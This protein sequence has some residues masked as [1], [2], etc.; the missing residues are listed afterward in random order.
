MSITLLSPS[1][2]IF[3]NTG[4]VNWDAQDLSLSIKMET[5][6]VARLK[7]TLIAATWRLIM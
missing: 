1:D 4:L 2:R 7:L 3:P 5:S 6:P